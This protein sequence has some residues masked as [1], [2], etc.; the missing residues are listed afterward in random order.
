M[1]TNR[2]L[3][4]FHAGAKIGEFQVW[5][6]AMSVARRK[7]ADHGKRTNIYP[8]LD[9]GTGLRLAACYPNGDVETGVVV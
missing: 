7:A 1:A 8:I 2:Y 4:V 3:V 6:N 5:D 9:Y